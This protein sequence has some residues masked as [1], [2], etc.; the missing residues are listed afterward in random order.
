[1][2]RNRFETL[3]AMRGLAA[4]RVIPRHTSIFGSGATELH[5][6]RAVYGFAV[7]LVLYQLRERA[8]QFNAPVA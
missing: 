1:M 6:Y 2:S 4:M 5:N 7:G 8:P 3:D